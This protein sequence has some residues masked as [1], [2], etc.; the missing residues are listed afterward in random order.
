MLT[1]D[2]L[3]EKLK[4]LDELSLIDI[5]DIDS[6]QIIERFIDKIEEQQDALRGDWEDEQGQ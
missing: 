1:I 6:E 2:E 4:W 5:L 3:C